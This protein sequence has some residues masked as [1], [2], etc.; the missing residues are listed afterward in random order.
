MEKY[1]SNLYLRN[2]I[3]HPNE[4]HE[5]IIAHQLHIY[6]YR[7]PIKPISYENG[8]FRSITVD[9]R[10]SLK[11]Q[12]EQFYHELCHILRHAGWQS[13]VMPIAFKELQE[14]DAR[15]FMRYAALPV[16][17]LK[18]I[19]FNQADIITYLSD[20]FKVSPKLCQERLEKIHSK[21]QYNNIS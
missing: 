18:D 20:I 12:R 21:T 13:D 15:H 10:S 19:D 8:R 17:M 2:Y 16:H 14:N 7:K 11:E 5:E 3:Y 1:I 6:L 4:L 9:S